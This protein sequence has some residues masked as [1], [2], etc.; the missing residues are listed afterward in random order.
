MTAI[1]IGTKQ[2]GTN[3][4]VR[5][6]A[7]VWLP[8]LKFSLI[9]VKTVRLTVL[10]TERIATGYDGISSSTLVLSS[11]HYALCWTNKRFSLYSDYS[12]HLCW[13]HLEMLAV[14][15]ILSVKPKFYHLAFF[16]IVQKIASNTNSII[17]TFLINT[18]PHRDAW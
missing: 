7:S 16:N 15:L 11:R 10:K 2:Q 3:F 5:W 13:D 12:V 18:D 6:R 4:H 8:F 9:L 1:T 14:V 17:G